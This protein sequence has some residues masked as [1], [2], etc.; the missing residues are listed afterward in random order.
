MGQSASGFD[1][2]LSGGKFGPFAKQLFVGDQTHS[3]V[4]RVYMEKINDRWQGACFPFRSGFGSGTVPVRFGKDGSLIVGGTNRGWGSRGSNPF[5]IERLAWTGKTPFEIHEMHA[6]PDGFE[7]TFTKP[8]DP[9]TAGKVESYQIS[10]FCYIYQAAY[11]SPVV[12]ETKPK[13]T[14]VEVSKDGKSV[15]LW[16]DKLEEGHIHDL[17]AVGVRNLEGEA[18]LHPQAY[19]TLNYIPGK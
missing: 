4:M 11:G 14:K 2:D 8:V 9:E 7:L 5:A 17:T 16:V 3:T 1:V 19:Y 13:I 12:D 15:R 18:L 10:T 6:K